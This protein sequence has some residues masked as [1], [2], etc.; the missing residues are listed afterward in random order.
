MILVK[1][2][3]T[4]W[5]G[6]FF[7][8]SFYPFWNLKFWWISERKKKAKRKQ[9]QPASKQKENPIQNPVH[10]PEYI[11]QYKILSIVPNT[12][13][14][15]ESVAQLDSLHSQLNNFI[16]YPQLFGGV[17][18]HFSTFSWWL[19]WLLPGNM[20]LFSPGTNR[21][22]MKIGN[23]KSSFFLGW[24]PGGAIA[25]SEKTA[26]KKESK[27][28]KFGWLNEPWPTSRMVTPLLGVLGDLW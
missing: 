19:F 4:F 9:K 8:L 23:G 21:S 13:P 11:F 6:F 25:V 5:G 17:I 12:F 3:C 1:V 24:L 16:H 7:W 15:T 26:C 28:Y 27:L 2:L 18:N 10:N 20:K 22:H 14:N